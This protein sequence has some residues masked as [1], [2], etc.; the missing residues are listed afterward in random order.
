MFHVLSIF[1]LTIYKKVFTL[2]NA[3]LPAATGQLK[4]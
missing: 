2:G 1:K 3:V 4:M